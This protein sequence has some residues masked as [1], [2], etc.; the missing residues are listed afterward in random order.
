[1]KKLVIIAVLL[2]SLPSFG[3]E[4]GPAVPNSSYIHS[5]LSIDEQNLSTSSSFDAFLKKLEKKQHS[6]KKEKDFVRFIFTKTHQEFLKEYKAY[7]S[8]NELF[9]TGDYN[10]L[11]GTI[12]YALVLN[13]FGIEH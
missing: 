11:T 3:F 4:P 7:A 8:F 1:L 13:H 2:L 5:F 10:C 12:L 6:L 9:S